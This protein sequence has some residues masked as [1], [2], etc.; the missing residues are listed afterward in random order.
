[1][2]DRILDKCK[3]P[4]DLPKEDAFQL[5]YIK[6]EQ[7][8]LTH[9]ENSRLYTEFKKLRETYEDDEAVKIK[10]Y[11]GKLYKNEE[12]VDQFDLLNQHF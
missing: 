3:T 6:Q 5:V 10:L 11:K 9:K 7:P 1:M 4:K 2:K 8:P 12:V